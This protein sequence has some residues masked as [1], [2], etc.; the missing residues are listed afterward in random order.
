M[1]KLDSIIDALQNANTGGDREKEEELRQQLQDAQRRRQALLRDPNSKEHLNVGKL[2]AV[3]RKAGVLSENDNHAP[4]SA[5]DENPDNET[6]DEDCAPASKQRRILER[7]SAWRATES[8]QPDT[9]RHQYITA[10]PQ[11]QQQHVPPHELQQQQQL[12]VHELGTQQN[13]HIAP[14]NANDLEPSLHAVA[15]AAAQA[16]FRQL[17]ESAS[18]PFQL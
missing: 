12:G 17:Q 1:R 3:K 7:S 10:T 6:G 14:T 8:Q 16:A 18:L 5:A 15:A 13:A 9:L 4:L 11:H 2:K